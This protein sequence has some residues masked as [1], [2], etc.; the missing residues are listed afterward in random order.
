MRVG[1]AMTP[2][3]KWSEPRLRRPDTFEVRSCD[4]EQK[5]LDPFE[6]ISLPEYLP[7]GA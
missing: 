5:K 2:G 4:E 1:D 7:R 6:M 3:V